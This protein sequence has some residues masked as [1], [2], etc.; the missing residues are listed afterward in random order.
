MAWASAYDGSKKEMVRSWSISSS[1]NE[2][3]FLNG[4]DTFQIKREESVKHTIERTEGMH[5]IDASGQLTHRQVTSWNVSWQESQYQSCEHAW[6]QA[7]AWPLQWEAL[8]PP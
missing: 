8:A 7:W 1:P 2:R 3:K 6:H 4:G 5:N